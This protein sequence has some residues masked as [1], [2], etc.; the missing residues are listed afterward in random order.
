MLVYCRNM[1]HTMGL[2]RDEI[3]S[4]GDDKMVDI[5]DAKQILQLAIDSE[6]SVFLDGSWGVDALIGYKTREHND[7]D[8][9]CF[10]YVNDGS[11]FYEEDSFPSKIFSGRGKIEGINSCNWWSGIRRKYHAG[12]CKNVWL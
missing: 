12:N 1:L 9:P 6:I 7:I 2:G 10:E 8:L 5:T 4:C 3:G 11:I